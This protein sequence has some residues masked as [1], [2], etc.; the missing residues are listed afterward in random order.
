MG[1]YVTFYIGCL[2]VMLLTTVEGAEG[3]GE[4]RIMHNS[5]IPHTTVYVTL[6][7]PLRRFSMLD[8][9][10]VGIVDAKQV[11]VATSRRELFRR[12]TTIV[13]YWHP[14]GRRAIEL[15][16]PLQGCDVH[17]ST[18]HALGAC[19]LPVRRGGV[20]HLASCFGPGSI[21]SL[22]G[23]GVM[24]CLASVFSCFFF[25]RPYPGMFLFA[26]S[27]Q[28]LSAPLEHVRVLFVPFCVLSYLIVPSVLV[29]LFFVVV[30]FL[31]VV[32][33]CAVFSCPV[34]WHLITYLD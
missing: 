21:P 7:T 4:R 17:R 13:R 6:M 18:R 1:I 8:I 9:S 2:Y 26:S 14:L 3:G 11:G 10:T 27:V 16:N 30:V 22:R 25:L 33:C 12:R 23:L 19:P 29:V 28:Q 24:H 20:S 34:R 15:G 31:V 32:F 5:D